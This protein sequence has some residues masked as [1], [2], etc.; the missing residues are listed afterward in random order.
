MSRDW[1]DLIDGNDIYKLISSEKPLSARC[2]NRKELAPQHL[3]FGCKVQFVTRI[4]AR[5]IMSLN[6]AQSLL[7]LYLL[8]S[9]RCIFVDVVNSALE[10]CNQ[11][12]GCKSG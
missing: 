4:F 11:G 12:K 9:V 2:L 5:C 3:D 1:R 6:A 7:L 10:L 8:D